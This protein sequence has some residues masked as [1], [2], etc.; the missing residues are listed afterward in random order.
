MPETQSALGAQRTQPISSG[1]AVV[2]SIKRIIPRMVD[3][4]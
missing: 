2:W 3:E 4:L 1:D